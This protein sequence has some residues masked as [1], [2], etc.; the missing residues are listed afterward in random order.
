MDANCPSMVSRIKNPKIKAISS[1]PSSQTTVTVR[2]RKFDNT[3]KSEWEGEIMPVHFPDWLFVL[4]HPERHLKFSQ[5][6]V[7]RSK[8]FFLHG[9]NLNQPLTVLFEY[10]TKGEFREAKCDAALPATRKGNLIEFTDLD[11]DLIV[12]PDFSFYQ[13]DE[14]QFAKNRKKMKYSKTVVAQARRGMMMAEVL[15]KTRRFP[16]NQDFVP[17]MKWLK[18]A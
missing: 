2:K 17:K 11:L 18:R 16:F 14:D 12:K 15:V 10:S 5:E 8:R 6:G 4:H 9:F 1:V 7:V 13:R 3:I